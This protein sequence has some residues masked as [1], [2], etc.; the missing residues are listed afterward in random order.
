MHT[1]LSLEKKKCVD[2]RR[3][4]EGDEAKRKGFYY[5]GL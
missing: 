2:V 3:M 5:K 1:N 4:F